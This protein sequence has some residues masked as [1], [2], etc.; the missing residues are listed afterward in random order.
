MRKGKPLI[1]IPTKFFEF[2]ST[3]TPSAVAIKW[4]GSEA[5]FEGAEDQLSLRHFENTGSTSFS[6]VESSYLVI[7]KLQHSRIC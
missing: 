7:K 1:Q 2:L 6:Y 4:S 5:R 3:Q